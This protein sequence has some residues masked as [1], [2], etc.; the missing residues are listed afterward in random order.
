M[1]FVYK[2]KNNHWYV[3]T[4]DKYG[5]LYDTMRHFKTIGEAVAFTKTYN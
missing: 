1:K 5:N 2:I 3:F 4:M